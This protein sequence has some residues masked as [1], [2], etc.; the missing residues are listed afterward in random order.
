MLPSDLEISQQPA[1]SVAVCLPWCWSSCIDR[2]F[3]SMSIR[4]DFWK[5]FFVIFGSYFGSFV[6]LKSFSLREARNGV[7]INQVCGTSRYSA[8]Y[9]GESTTRQWQD[10]LVERHF[11]RGIHQNFLQ[12]NQTKLN[13]QTISLCSFGLD[14][15]SCPQA[16]TSHTKL[17]LRQ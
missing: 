6:P 15:I 1:A 16:N 3:A 5:I 12:K 8:K 10:N 9:H 13:V 4:G 17:I 7:T 11:M 2:P 14:C